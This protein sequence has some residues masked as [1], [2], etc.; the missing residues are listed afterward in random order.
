MDVT[1][2]LMNWPF[3]AFFVMAV[4]ML[5]SKDAVED[6]ACVLADC[7]EL[8]GQPMRPDDLK[9]GSARPFGAARGTS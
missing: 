6:M 3:A 5:L 8:I 2:Q 4:A 9:Q 7:L 1:L